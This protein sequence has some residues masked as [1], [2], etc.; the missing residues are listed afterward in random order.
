VDLQAL[1]T[2]KWPYKVAA[3]VL[4]VLVWLNVTANR[5]TQDQDITTRL[6]YEVRDSAW[7]IGTAQTEVTTVFQG[8]SGDIIALFNEPVIRVVI[9]SVEDSLVQVEL[10]VDDVEYDRTLSVRATSVLP[11]RV[12]VHLEPRLVRTVP[13]LPMT[14]ASPSAGYA[15]D[16]TVVQPDSVVLSGPASAVENVVA[17]PTE[18]LELG[19]LSESVTRPA[20]LQP[21]ASARGVDLRPSGVSLTVEVDSMIV[22]RFQVRIVASG[23][24]AAGASVDPAVVRVDISGAART[25]AGLDPTD[26]VAS[27]R[28]DGP[29]TA[30][31]EVPV[32]VRLPAGVNARAAAAPA[33]V[34]VSP[35]SSPVGGGS[36]EAGGEGRR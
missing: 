9:E 26:L 5:E 35:A 1:F 23:D 29:L 11:S 31:I 19:E 34:I 25:V 28:I 30:P 14:D 15:I 6:E 13:V 33:V 10:D 16:R 18:R 2:E 3:I 7:A 21:P 24:A 20:A 32:Q 17:I 8:R 36:T 22:R 12:T 27:V 4:S